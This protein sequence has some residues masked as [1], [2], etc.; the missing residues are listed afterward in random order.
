MSDKGRA[1]GAP[2][3]RDHAPLQRAV[4]VVLAGGHRRD[5]R[6]TPGPGLLRGEDGKHHHRYRPLPAQR[7]PG[8]G[9]RVRPSPRGLCP[10]LLLG[11]KDLR[12]QEV[13][14]DDF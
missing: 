12:R 1:G 2:D 14:S 7:R 3:P 10:R 5:G 8:R 4:A 11:G 9:A 13:Q 6:A